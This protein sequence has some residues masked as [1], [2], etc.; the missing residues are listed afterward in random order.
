LE[1]CAVL[2]EFSEFE[3]DLARFELRRGGEPVRIE[4]RPLEVL[5]YLASNRD[6]VV[7]KEE[8]IERL[9]GVK[10]ISES[11]LTRCIH[12]ARR[13]LG[14][15][16]AQPAVIKTVH[17]RG[18][19]FIAEVVERSDEGIA[20]APGERVHAAQAPGESRDIGTSG[21]A[22]PRAWARRWVGV[23]V[24]TAAI[25]ASVGWWVAREVSRREPPGAVPRGRVAALTQLTAGVQD[26]LKPCYSP[27]GRSLLFLSQTPDRPGTLDLFLMPAGGGDPLRLTTGAAA[28]G[29]I[30][31]F[32]AD[33]SHIAFSRFRSGEDG[34]RL[35]DLW[36]VSRFGGEARVFIGGA[37]GAGFSGD[38]EWVAYTKH[39]GARSPLWLS[40]VAALDGHREIAELGFVPRWSPGDLWIAYTTSDPQ[41]GL[42]HLWVVSPATG[43]RRRLTE[44]ATQMYG[45]AWARDGQSVI[46]AALGGGYFHLWQVDTG[47]GYVAPLT[48]GLSEHTS[49]TVAP[50]GKTLAFCHS[51]P[52]YKLVRVEGLA[53]PPTA[54]IAQPEHHVAPRL[55]PSGWRIASAIRRPDAEDVL[56][57]TDLLTQRQVRLSDRRSGQPCWL[58]D[59]EIAFTITDAAPEP[60]TE[61]WVVN[62]STGMRFSWTRLRSDASWLAVHPDMT[63]LAFVSRSPTGTQSVVMRNLSDRSEQTIASGGEYAC[64]RWRPGAAELSW[65]GPIDSADRES[66]GIWLASVERPTRTQLVPDGYGPVWSAD[67]R[68]AY[69][70]RAGELSGLWR[71]DAADRSVELVRPWQEVSAFDVVGDRLF[72]VQSAGRSQVFAMPLDQ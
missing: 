5:I 58:S 55:A 19:R 10:F 36:I 33:G 23:A 72:F 47:G 29:D 26:A 57:L 67:G 1:A 56:Y 65:S 46:Y 35:P 16:G 60:T 28:S 24:A 44:E 40:R 37:S 41:G 50:D 31:V 45:L 7:T 34:S 27:D 61:V 69:F 64:L 53:G 13:V 63:R 51:Q 70:S 3:L 25:L 39:T 62:A 59:D 30:P 12:E 54:E 15:D 14:D 2:L 52:V 32:T 49:P 42:G 66:N 43:E 11:A 4:P 8:L 6:R 71:V 17:G 21:S 18:Y 20:S 48:T 38:G 9:W 22:A 68:A